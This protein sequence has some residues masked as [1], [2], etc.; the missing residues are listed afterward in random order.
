MMMT[1]GRDG[2]AQRR[3]QSLGSEQTLAVQQTLVF[4]TA[5]WRIWAARSKFNSYAC[6]SIEDQSLA[7]PHDALHGKPYSQ[8]M[9]FEPDDCSRVAHNVVSFA[10]NSVLTPSIVAINSVEK[11]R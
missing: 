3:V 9:W 8:K 2:D 6:V 5:I 10:I 1:G 7:L 4:Y 11:P